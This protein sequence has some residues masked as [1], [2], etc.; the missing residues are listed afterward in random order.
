M[1]GHN[2]GT[3][4]LETLFKCQTLERL[5]RNLEQNAIAASESINLDYSIN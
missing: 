3:H 1:L 4:L 2:L 5:E